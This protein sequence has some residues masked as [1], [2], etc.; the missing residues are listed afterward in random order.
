MHVYARQTLHRKVAF[1]AVQRWAH[2]LVLRVRGQSAAQRGHPRAQP[3][4]S[5]LHGG[6]SS[7]I[8]LCV[9][10]AF[11]ASGA[12]MLD[13]HSHSQPPLQSA[14]VC[15]MSLLTRVSPSLKKKPMSSTGMA[16]TACW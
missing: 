10:A 6:H 14:L 4:Q 1:K 5:C 13:A 3:W 15:T 9:L 11:K 8:Q 16:D 2:L 12:S 7:N